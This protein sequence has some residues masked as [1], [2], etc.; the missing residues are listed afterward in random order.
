[1]SWI[2]QEIG[3]IVQLNEMISAAF[4][5]AGADVMDLKPDAKTWSMNEC[6]DHII[7][8]NQKY[9]DIF[10]AIARGTYKAGLWAHFPILP[11]LL[12]KTVVKRISPDYK[13]KSQTVPLFYPLKST[14]GKNIALDLLEENNILI[15]KIRPCKEEDLDSVMVASP[16]TGF[17]IYSLRD[18]ITILV[19]HEKRHYN[20]AMRLK[21]H[22]EKGG[23]TPPP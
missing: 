6:F 10:D 8:S 9:Y 3:E 2:E 18:C 1:M 20:Q 21:A 22:V 13:G 7:Q 16:V 14:Y 12:G 23:V 4:G 15:E 19:E 5:A 11:R 17:V